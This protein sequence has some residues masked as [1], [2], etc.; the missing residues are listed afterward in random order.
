MV[1]KRYYIFQL[2]S[3]F[4]VNLYI[5]ANYLVLTT[6]Q[7]CDLELIL[8]NG[9]APLKTFMNQ[10]DYESVILNMRLTDNT[11][12]PI[13]ITLDVDQQTVKT[14]KDNNS[15]LIL[16]HPEG[17]ELALLE[18]NEIWKP[19]K[20]IEA[21]N[22]YGTT[23]IEHPGVNYLLNSTKEYYIS[24]KLTKIRLP[25]HYDF[26]DLRKTPEDLKN[27]FKEKGI[28]KVVGFQTRNPMHK[29]HKELTSRAAQSTNA[30]LLIHP[31]V[32]QTK[33]GDVDHFTR[34]RC[35]K[36]LLKYYPQDSVTLSLLPI[37]MRMAGP[38]EALW[39]A[40]I[41]K[42]YGCTHF[43]IGRDHAGPGK[44][45]NGKDFY[46]P[47]DAQN[48]V[49]QYEKEI[50]I[51]ILLFNEMVY[52][53]DQNTYKPENEIES[54]EKI[55]R[56]S[57]TQLRQLLKEAKEIPGWFT[58][59]EIAQE[60]KK[61]YPP[62][63][64][65]GF[66]IFFTG[67]PSSGKS[68][69]ANALAIKLSEIQNRSITVLDGDLIRNHLSKELGFSKEHR[70]IN[71]QRVGFV[72]NEITKNGG[73]AICA[74]IAPYE[75]DRRYN[76]ELITRGGY[77]EVYVS[78]PLNVCQERDEKGLYAKAK[79]GKIEMLTGISDPYESP[80]NPEI[81]IDTSTLSVEECIEQ[82]I[83]HLKLEQYI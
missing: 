33:P 68:T 32:G 77:I 1:I 27:Y 41:R 47:Y 46:G 17:H 14:L 4:F 71:V 70:S 38:R 57:G 10:K 18:V 58:Y 35:Y 52:S 7:L 9:F 30:H 26:T 11:V 40:I 19:N 21:I 29:A 45:S 31:V 80:K 2:I 64:N 15:R 49:K 53:V 22:V 13:P 56:I 74:L 69:I 6:R 55:L 3:I 44:D 42:N 73:V 83:N 25:K 75:Q 28:T 65:Q 5:N 82:I 39:H 63:F 37:S 20:E 78:T 54:N 48:L 51:N 81:T 24:G 36:Q 61:S 12:W 34:V 50:G 16:K 8:N 67:L 60:L 76:R 79:E 66:T 72:A 43:I 23:N 62:K 59:P